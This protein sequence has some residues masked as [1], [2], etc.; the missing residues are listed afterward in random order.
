M[1]QVL[2]DTNFILSCARQ[3]ID[4]FHEIPMMGIEV[5]IPRQVIDEIKLLSKSKESA[6][7][8]EEADLAMKLLNRNKFTLVKLRRKNADRGIIEFANDNKDAIIATLDKDLQNK[9]K[10]QKMIIKGLK[11]LE[12]I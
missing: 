2:L 3:K 4:F 5:L 6:I 12:I 10:N 9:I 8:R 7:I 1:K 11:T